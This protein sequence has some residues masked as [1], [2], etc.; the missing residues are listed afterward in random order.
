MLWILVLK[1]KKIELKGEMKKTRK[2]REWES[3][4]VIKR[5]VGWCLWSFFC[6]VFWTLVQL[7]PPLAKFLFFQPNHDI[8][9]QLLFFLLIATSHFSY[10][11]CSFSAL[12]A[13]FQPHLAAQTQVNAWDITWSHI[14]GIYHGTIDVICNIY[15]SAIILLEILLLNCD[16]IHL[17]SVTE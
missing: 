9:H 1:K 3:E 17:T 10:C 12:C 13:C 8:T 2:R 14:V 4:E 5:V 16:L 15:F 7:S 11:F 6:V